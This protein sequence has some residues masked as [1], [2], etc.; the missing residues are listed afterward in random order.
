MKKTC[1]ITAV[2]LVSLMSTASYATAPPEGALSVLGNRIVNSDDVPVSFAG[3]SFFW[4]NDG[5]GGEQYYNAA[6]LNWLVNDWHVEIVRAAMGV[7]DGGGYIGSP[8]NNK[9]RLKTIVDASI[10]KGIYVIIDW[11]SHHA[12][13]YESQAISFFQEMA[14]TYGGYDNVIYEIYN[15]PL[16]GCS[17]EN[18]IKP[19]AEA[20]IGA[21]R[22]IDPDNL[23][24]VGSPEW[25]QR[26]DLPAG[27]P[28]TGYINIAY[29]LH[30]YPDMGHTSWLRSRAS[31]AMSNG[32]A[33]MV[34]EWGP[35]GISGAR[36]D[37]SMDDLV[38]SEPSQP[39]RLGGKRQ[40]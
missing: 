15:E 40:K 5:W 14:T 1:L 10:A 20:V 37:Y 11:H 31:S 6:C 38:G 35:Q 9:N 3:V 19:Y 22:A 2:I 21:I 26:V 25:S 24:V 8:T 32:I 7:E 33:L 18:D 29:T 16:S 13:D 12:E 34:T 4:S 28:I 17:W 36:G 23:I 27:N 30:F 39:H